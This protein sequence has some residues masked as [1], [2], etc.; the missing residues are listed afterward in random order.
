MFRF[1]SFRF[2]GKENHQR[3]GDVSF[4]ILTTGKGAWALT[5]FSYVKLNRRQI[6][7][8]QTRTTE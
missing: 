4:D 3:C 5:V 1:V 8:T 2:N 7:P 6:S